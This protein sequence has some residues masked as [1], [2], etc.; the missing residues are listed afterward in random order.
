MCTVT[1]KYILFYFKAFHGV[2]FY[3]ADF[4]LQAASE[5]AAAGKSVP[6]PESPSSKTAGR[7]PAPGRHTQNRR[8]YSQQSAG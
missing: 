2:R 3:G 5:T 4:I 6:F 8:N 7:G 1:I